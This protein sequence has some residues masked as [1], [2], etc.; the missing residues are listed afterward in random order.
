[1]GLFVVIMVAVGVGMAYNRGYLNISS[2]TEVLLQKALN[3]TKVKLA[4]FEKERDQDI[5]DYKQK[6]SNL[7]EMLSSKTDIN[8]MNVVCKKLNEEKTVFFQ[9]QLDR[10]ENKAGKLEARNE[11]LLNDV[12]QCKALMNQVNSQLASQDSSWAS[13]LIDNIASTLKSF[14]A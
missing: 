3:E 5:K 9:E 6:I 1:M 12:V 4:Q 8:A 14:T 13:G 7:D 10:C 2:P 11:E